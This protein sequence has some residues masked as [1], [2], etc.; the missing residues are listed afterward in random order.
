MQLT[1]LKVCLVREI[2]GKIK[3]RGY[4]INGSRER[5]SLSSIHL[6]TGTVGGQ[7]WVLD[8]IRL[9]WETGP[10]KS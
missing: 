9:F 8:P 1:H 2:L 4:R 7:S 10:N 3:R 6:T 5:G